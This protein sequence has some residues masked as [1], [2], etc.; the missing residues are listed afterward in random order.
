MP[1]PNP[2]AQSNRGRVARVRSP[3]HAAHTY[4]RRRIPRLLK[5]VS[6]Q[7]T[8]SV[9]SDVGPLKRREYNDEGNLAS[10]IDGMD[11]EEGN[12]ARQASPE[13]GMLGIG[14]G[15]V[16]DGEKDESG[17]FADFILEVR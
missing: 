13:M 2:R 6:R 15:L 1:H 7:K 5:T 9:R 16:D 14:L 11:V 3:L 12:R 17:I 4:T 8:H 10:E